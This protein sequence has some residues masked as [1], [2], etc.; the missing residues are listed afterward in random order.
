MTTTMTTTTKMIHHNGKK[1][2]SL[3]TLGWHTKVD[4]IQDMY[5]YKEYRKGTSCSTYR[6]L[7]KMQSATSRA[8][9]EAV[10]PTL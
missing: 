7:S 9:V 1:L 3:Y 8:M 10:K 4:I 6:K 2:L 5:G